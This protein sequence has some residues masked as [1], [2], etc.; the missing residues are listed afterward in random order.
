M[1][2]IMISTETEHL[3]G[4]ARALLKSGLEEIER[5]LI[6]DSARDDEAHLL[7]GDM[8]ALDDALKGLD[9]AIYEGTYGNWVASLSP[10]KREEYDGIGP[11]WTT[12]GQ[13]RFATF[14][15]AWLERNP[16]KAIPEKPTC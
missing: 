3:L 6:D 10:A 14:K 2:C 9:W 1:V 16:G 7:E 5:K 13:R 11:L 12:G 15:R 4:T 8:I